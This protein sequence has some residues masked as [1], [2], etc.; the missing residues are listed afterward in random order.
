MKD[1]DVAG[2]DWLCIASTSPTPFPF[3]FCSFPTN[4]LPPSSH[5]HFPFLF[6]ISFRSPFFLFALQAFRFPFSSSSVSRVSPSLCL[7]WIPILPLS[8]LL[9]FSS[10]FHFLLL[11]FLF[12]P[13]FLRL[14][15]L[16]PFPS[17]PLL[18]PV[19]YTF[20]SNLT[21][22]PSPTSTPSIY[23]SSSLPSGFISCFLLLLFSLFRYYHLSSSS[24][25]L[26][27]V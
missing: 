7:T 9:S 23:H 18:Y 6:F 16:F 14:L 2:K 22:C 26:P 21:S 24:S 19:S 3:P 1:V 4:H 17:F 25:Q 12:M 13:F 10:L 5:L 15:L 11:F 27:P 8:L 20:S